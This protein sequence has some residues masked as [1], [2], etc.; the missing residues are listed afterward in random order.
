[1]RGISGGLTFR[2]KDLAN[3]DGIELG[4]HIGLHHPPLGD[5]A[6]A[7]QCGEGVDEDIL[8]GVADDPVAFCI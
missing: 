7:H 6:I 5:V 2:A 1:M 4:G 8:D 3:E